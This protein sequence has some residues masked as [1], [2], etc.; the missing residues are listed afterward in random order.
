[1]PQP[2]IPKKLK[3]TG[4]VKTYNMNCSLP[5]SSVHGSL[6]ARILEWVA[7]PSSG[8]SSQPRDQTPDSCVFCLTG[9][10]FAAEPPGKPTRLPRP[11]D[12]PGKNT[13]VGCHFLLRGIFPTQGSN[14]HLLLGRQILYCLSHQG[15]PKCVVILPSSHRKLMPGIRAQQHG[16]QGPG[17]RWGWSQAGGS[18]TGGRTRQAHMV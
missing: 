10:F 5:G 16:I 4:S 15:N 14:S 7:T 13:G 17:S 1:M 8:G 3:L 6:Q 2:P 18:G 9:R 12:S 11:W